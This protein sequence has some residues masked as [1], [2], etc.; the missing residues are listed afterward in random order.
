M[1]IGRGSVRLIRR[2]SILSSLAVF[3]RKAAAVA[4]PI[5]ARANARTASA[6]FGLGDRFLALV[7]LVGE[8]RLGGRL[9]RYGCLLRTASLGRALRGGQVGELQIHG[10]DRH[11]RILPHEASVLLSDRSQAGAFGDIFA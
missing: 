9:C 10:T 7:K 1:A 11:Y 4:L 3:G 6:V 5:G 2:P 8:R